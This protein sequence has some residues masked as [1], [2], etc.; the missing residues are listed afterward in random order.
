MISIA[1][2]CSGSGTNLQ[3]ILDAA[4]RGEFDGKVA[5]VVADQKEAFALK[6]A[7]AAGVET[8]FIDPNTFSGKKAYEEKLIALLDERNIDLICL[9]GYMRL[10]S[11]LFIAHYKNKILNIHPALLP[12]FKGGNAIDD[13]LAF[14]AKVTGVTVHFATEKLDNGPILLQ[15]SVSV[16]EGDTPDAL[17]ERVHAVEHKLYPKAIQLIAAGRVSV[18]GRRVTILP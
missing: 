16:E 15:E 2:F 10:L 4:G 3:A 8:L 18:K 7:E 1:V 12:A 17:L 11:P 14:G 6:L 5:V 9:A 13:A